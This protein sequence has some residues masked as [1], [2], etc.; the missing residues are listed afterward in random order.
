MVR[1]ALFIA[2]LLAPRIAL[3][4]EEPKHEPLVTEPAP[5]LGY[6]YSAYVADARTI[7][8]RAHTTALLDRKLEMGGG[9]TVWGSP[10]DRV[11]LIADAQRSVEGP[12]AP[13]FA[14]IVRL[15][16]GLSALA[17][18][19]IDG[20][21]EGPEGE[22][23]SELEAGLL[24]SYARESFHADVNAIAG[25]GLG[26]EGEVDSE[27]RAR[28]GLD[29]TSHVRVGADGQ[30]RFRLAG[31]RRLPG[32]RTWDFAAGPQIVVAASPFFAAL[33]SGPCTMST[34]SKLGWSSIL[35]LGAATF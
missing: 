21:A 27:A 17:K 9:A 28:I 31:D 2:L 10:I 14:G 26:D 32:N 22:M 16:G 23:E 20:F 8:A 15:V 29:V 5:I 1:R 13:S 12:F 19:K 6:A 11:L 33:T 30:G 25:A 7:G 18:F 3:A 35:S 4:E 24:F 34:A